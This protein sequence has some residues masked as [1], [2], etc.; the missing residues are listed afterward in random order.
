MRVV[1]RTLEAPREGFTATVGDWILRQE[2][3][4]T[5]GELLPVVVQ[6]AAL[7]GGLARMLGQL[8]LRR[9]AEP[10]QSLSAFLAAR[11]GG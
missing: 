2:T 4:V 10:V 3:L 6:H 1:D 11:Q 7:V 8:G 9:R 5:D